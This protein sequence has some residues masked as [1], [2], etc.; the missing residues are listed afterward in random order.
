MASDVDAGSLRVGAT[1]AETD[2]LVNAL[3]SSLVGAY[4]VDAGPNGDPRDPENPAHI[5]EASLRQKIPF[6]FPVK[7]WG[8]DGTEEV[9]VPRI[10][11]T[12]YNAHETAWGKDLM[13]YAVSIM[14]REREF[15][16]ALEVLDFLG[17]DEY[18]NLMTAP[19]LQVREGRAW[20]SPDGVAELEHIAT[21]TS[22]HAWVEAYV[23]NYKTTVIDPWVQNYVAT[24]KTSTLDPYIADQIAKF[25]LPPRTIVMTTLTK[26]NILNLPGKWAPC[27]GGTYTLLAGGN[28]T[29]PDLR[30]L[31]VRGASADTEI[32]VGYGADTINLQ[33]AH[34]GFQHY[35]DHYHSMS[36]D[37]SMSHSHGSGSTGTPSD[38]RNKSAP[39]GSQ[40][41]NYAQDTHTH[42]FSVPSMSGNTGGTN[43][44]T[45]GW[46]DNNRQGNQSDTG[47]AL[48]TSQTIMNAHR[49]FWFMMKL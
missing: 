33:H 12:P 28:V 38:W 36:H 40:D 29:T 30:G 34:S 5:D 24:Y 43:Q 23:A 32:G 7:F 1:Q 35:H 37:H 27:D 31:G 25:C 47:V 26:V 45:T 17:Y 21:E 6:G 41:L 8:W 11:R 14:S 19:I 10:E 4:D 2:S 39:T 48:S 46:Q 49:R 20:A 42:N 44:G 3:T 15:G 9:A 13:S 22:T 18:G 16:K